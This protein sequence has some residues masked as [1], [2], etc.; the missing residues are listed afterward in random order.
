MTIRFNNCSLD[1]ETGEFR[2]DGEVVK[3]EPMV[4]DLLVFLAMSGGRLVPK[5]ELVE[6]VWNGRAV[7]DAAIDSRISA[8]RTAIGDL[9]PERHTIV[10]VPR[11]GVRFIAD[12]SSDDAG[13]AVA[14]AGPVPERGRDQ[15]VR[16]C[17]SRDGTT[18]AHAVS[19]S[20]PPLVRVGHWL[21]HVEHD[22]RSIIWAPF[23]DRLGASFTVHRYDQRGSGLSDRDVE[24]LDLEAFVEDLE[25]VVEANGLDRFVL[26]GS[27][28][29]APVAAAYAARH[30]ERVDRLILHGGYVT[31][32]ALRPDPEEREQGEAMLSLIRTGWGRPG[33]QFLKA[34]SAIYIPD[35]TS[36]QVD[37][38]AELQKLS[39]TPEMAARIRKAVDLFDVAGLLPAISVP[40]LVLH[41]RDD[42]VQPA[43][44]GRELARLI[45][46]ATFRLFQSR[47]HVILPQEADW[48]RQF[49]LIG[50]F[51]GVRGR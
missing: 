38:L 12:V 14:A 40:A 18:L 37:A 11:R 31:G 22:W 6:A 8:A 23:L 34:F 49:H 48:G 21:T 39:A 10:T 41:A 47:N 17:R 19:G 43:E 7:S 15:S 45:P 9:G 29:G 26:Y 32:R 27:S 30:P 20:G 1:R 25:A 2:V 35:G 50:D 28:Q 3:L 4:F 46:G 13:N 36:E 16:F 44:Q 5:E 51:C 42:A 33:G 24:Q